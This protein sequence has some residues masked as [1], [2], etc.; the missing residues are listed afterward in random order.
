MEKEHPGYHGDAGGGAGGGGGGGGGGDTTTAAL[1]QSVSRARRQSMVAMA[2]GGR[3]GSIQIE[4]PSEGAVGGGAAAAQTDVSGAAGGGGPGG[5]SHG[6]NVGRRASLTVEEMQA[7]VA[8]LNERNAS[9]QVRNGL[10]SAFCR[11]LL[12]RDSLTNYLL[13]DS[14]LIVSLLLVCCNARPRRRVQEK[15]E[16]AQLAA[17]AELEADIASAVDGGDAGKLAAHLEV[18]T[19]A[20]AALKAEVS[21]LTTQYV[22]VYIRYSLLT[23]DWCFLA[24]CS[25][26]SPAPPPLL[27]RGFPLA[28]FCYDST[29]TTCWVLLQERAPAGRALA[30]RPAADAVAREPAAAAGGAGGGGGPDPRGGHRARRGRRGRARRGAGGVGGGRGDLRAAAVAGGGDAPGP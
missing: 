13:V 9:V 10:T 15:A 24:C 8:A 6:G 4:E 14:R 27:T 12:T 26:D 20:K 28:H 23:T 16:A 29:C 3:R 22:L 5:A 7:K 19:A 30:R 21:Q 2:G 1:L 25:T 18:A 17:D 11:L